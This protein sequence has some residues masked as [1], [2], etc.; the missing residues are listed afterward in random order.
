MEHNLYEL[1]AKAKELMERLVN[2][3]AFEQVL[4]R[5]LTVIDWA[6]SKEARTMPNLNWSK[7]ASRFV[8][9]ENDSPYVFKWQYIIDDIDYCASE[10]YIY[11]KAAEYGI[12]A[13]FAWTAKVCD[14][15]G[16]AIYA[17]EKCK[18]DSI[19]LSDDSYDFHWKLA[20]DN[21]GYDPDN[22]TDE[23]AEDVGD[24][25]YDYNDT[26]GLIDF[27][28]EFWDAIIIEDLRD[29][30]EEYGLCDLHSGNWGYLDGRLV[31]TDYA[32]YEV[33]LID[34]NEGRE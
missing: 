20:C 13:C 12:G 27:A 19:K 29:F 14:Y 31:L 23:Q 17:M 3:S 30:V 24:E 11:Q 6:R 26:D 28:G 10:A 15:G 21:L 7:G 33:D 18:V 34:L 25:M 9:W 22:L 16:A 2:E 1:G 4:N 5:E 32:G 8:F